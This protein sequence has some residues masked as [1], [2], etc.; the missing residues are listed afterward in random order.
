LDVYPEKGL[1]TYRVIAIYVIGVDQLEP[2]YLK[3][4]YQVCQLD[5]ARYAVAG[6]GAR[7]HACGSRGV[8]Q[9]ERIMFEPKQ[10]DRIHPQL[11]E[12]CDDYG[13]Y[14]AETHR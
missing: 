14:F 2:R 10:K 7:C 9:H 5:G 8:E 1:V 12:A 11:P 3:H 6:V 13:L 4:V